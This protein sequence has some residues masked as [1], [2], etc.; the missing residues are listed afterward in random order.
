MDEEKF[1]LDA[2][3]GLRSMWFNKNNPYAIFLDCDSD[4]VLYARKEK[5]NRLRGMPG[6]KPALNFRVPTTP[7]DFRH[8][9]YPDGRFKII[10]F[11]PPHR[12]DSGRNSFFGTRYALLNPETWPRDMKEAANE[13]WRVLAPFGV[14]LF[15]WSDSQIKFKDIL[16]LFFPARPF[17]GQISAGAKAKSGGKAHTC[18]FCF[19]KVPEEQK[20]MGMKVK[21]DPDEPN[22][23]L[24]FEKKEEVK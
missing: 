21:I 23:R 14:L 1:V 19:V 15:K 6:R 13:L 17:F 3:S 4:D 16:R 18:W 2:T 7:G 12:S 10:V 24:E 5:Y 9:P 22:F 8:L 11:D 20:F